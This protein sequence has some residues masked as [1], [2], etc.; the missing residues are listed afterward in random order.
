MNKNL[1]DLFDVQAFLEMEEETAAVAMVNYFTNCV[2]TLRDRSV[3]V[4]VQV[5]LNQQDPKA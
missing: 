5:Y 1:G 4:Q 2:A 3:Y